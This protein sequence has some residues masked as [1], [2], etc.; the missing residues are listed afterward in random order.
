MKSI[1][2][3]N[4]T[5]TDADV[6]AIVQSASSNRRV[7]VFDKKGVPTVTTD[8]GTLIVG[9]TREDI[10]PEMLAFIADDTDMIYTMP[11]TWTMAHLCKRLAMF[12]SVTQAQKN[13]K[14]QVPMGFSQ[15]QLKVNHVR[16]VLT[17]YR[18]DTAA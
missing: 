3:T 18:I 4:E 9:G 16:G 8:L 7:T 11:E 12:P 1:D 13:G 14:G 17:V 6:A 10:D 2:L 5:L 15:H